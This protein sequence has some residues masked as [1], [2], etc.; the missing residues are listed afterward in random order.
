[1]IQ[2][3]LTLNP[4]KKAVYQHDPYFA[5]ALGAALGAWADERSLSAFLWSHTSLL[6]RPEAILAR[7]SRAIFPILRAHG[8]IPV[9]IRRIRITPQQAGLLWRYQSN[10]MTPGHFLLLQRLLCAGPSIY[11]VLRDYSQRRSTPAAGHVTYLKGP[12]LMSRRKP[13]HLRSLAGPAIAN[14]L[15]YI[16]VSDDPAD[17][18]RELAILFSGKILVEILLQ[19]AAGKDHTGDGLAM[20]QA[21][22]LYAP[23]IALA[24]AG[25]ACWNEEHLVSS[26]EDLP[27]RREW[28]EILTRARTNISYVGGEVYDTR[29]ALIPDDKRYLAPLDSHLIRLDIG[30]GF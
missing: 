9:S 16:H 17:F 28:A 19:A 18:L 29:A 6:L 24:G 5:A 8:L 2:N 4:V 1:M 22:E 13:L 11:I 26:F 25:T 10:V 23:K 21:A 30:P 3:V 14:I 20:L 15:S 27:L 12:T 7:R